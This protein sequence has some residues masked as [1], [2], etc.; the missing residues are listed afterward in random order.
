M[1]KRDY[2]GVKPGHWV[3]NRLSIVSRK[4]ILLPPALLKPAV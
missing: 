3:D 2:P 4:G 1:L